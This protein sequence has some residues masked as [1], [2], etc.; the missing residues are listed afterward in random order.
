MTYATV[1]VAL[2]DP[3]RRRIFE[4][5]R[6]RPHTVGE[7]ADIVDIR[8]PTVTQHLQVLR[9]ARL[10][11]DRRDGTRHYY[12]ASSEGLAALRRYVESLWDD[13]LAAYADDETARPATRPRSSKGRIR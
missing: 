8:Q 12:S 4:R 7:L 1:L 10:V 9:R 6:K 3:T 13:V 11:T 5:L 2:A